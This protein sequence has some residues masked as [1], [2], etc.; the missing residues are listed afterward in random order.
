M[1]N[2][3]TWEYKELPPRR[4]AI[5]LKW[6]FKVKYYP[7]SV[8]AKFKAK[9]VA[10]KFFQVQKI[11]FSKIF[12]L[13]VRKKS[14]QIYLTLCLILNLFIHQVDIV[15]AYLKSLVGDNKLPI[16]MKLLPGMHNRRQL[17]K[18]LLYKLLESLYNLK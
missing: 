7:N 16:F 5:G 12:I 8:I 11:N 2:H 13:T 18:S 9:L 4:K 15:I 1:E 10:Q 6:V 3:Q 17:Q 14:L